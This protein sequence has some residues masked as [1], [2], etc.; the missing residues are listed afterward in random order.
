MALLQ[1]SAGD[2][3]FCDGNRL[4]ILTEKD[5]DNEAGR[6]AVLCEKCGARG[7]V[8][9]SRVAACEQWNKRRQG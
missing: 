9:A 3:P 7:P 1:F 4:V 6:N 5:D 8:T 2:C